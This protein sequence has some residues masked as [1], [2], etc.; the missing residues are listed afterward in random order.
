MAPLGTQ[1]G[2]QR[3][4]GHGPSLPVRRRLVALCTQAAQR[5][6]AARPAWVMNSIECPES[7][8]WPRFNYHPPRCRTIACMSISLF[9][10]QQ[11][12]RSEMRVGNRTVPVL[13]VHQIW[14]H[15]PSRVRR[16]VL[17]VARRYASGATLLLRWFSN[18]V[19]S[20]IS[21]YSLIAYQD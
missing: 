4:L 1:L 7:S 16:Y 21:S 17:S 8:F 2:A 11:V 20:Y 19:S 3:F 12:G 13:S 6:G 9:S 10:I 15:R 14:R 18:K 5:D